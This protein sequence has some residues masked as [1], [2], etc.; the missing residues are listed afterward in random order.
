MLGRV[1]FT[2]RQ[3]LCAPCHKL[4]Q[5][6]PGLLARIILLISLTGVVIHRAISSWDCLNKE[7]YIYI[8]Y[9]WNFKCLTG[10]WCY[11][12]LCQER[13]GVGEPKEQAGRWEAAHRSRQRPAASLRVCYRLIHVIQE[14][15]LCLWSAGTL[16]PLH[17]K[18]FDFDSAALLI[19]EWTSLF[20]SWDLVKSFSP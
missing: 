14:S 10:A 13:A 16:L 4:N 7:K 12:L 9:Q 11:K 8:K 15:G 6:Q 17:L 18:C 19:R 2:P 1:P 20:K 5:D 3:A